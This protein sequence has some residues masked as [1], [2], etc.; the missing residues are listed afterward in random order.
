MGNS[1]LV[2]IHTKTQSEYNSGKRLSILW[3]IVGG[4]ILLFVW[5]AVSIWSGPLLLAT[6]LKTFKALFEMAKDGE[7]YQ[8]CVLTIFR[9]SGIML[10]AGILGALLAGIAVFDWRIAEVLEP[11]RRVCS[12]VPPIVLAVVVMFWMG[13]GSKMILVFGVLILWPVMY[14]NL[15][16]GSAIC[17]TELRETA[18]VFRLSLWTRIRHFY[19]PALTPAC[20]TGSIQLICSAIRVTVLAEVMG[21][22]NGVGAAIVSSSRSLDIDRMTAW[23]LMALL[24][25]VLAEMVLLGPVRERVYRWKNV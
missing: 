23:V 9:V 10:L 6:P 18:A 15:I 5:W 12:T 24:F 25:A 21:A 17:T 14:V 19:L 4:V 3:A 11:W 16:E 20:L 7:L 8:H 13:M 22:E 2:G 1:N